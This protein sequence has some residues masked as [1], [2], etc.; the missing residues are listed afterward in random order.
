[1]AIDLLEREVRGLPE[2][3]ILRVIEFVR[4]IKYEAAQKKAKTPRR[5]PGHFSD[6]LLYIADDFDDTPE[7]FEEYM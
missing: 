2:E 7:G 3:D 6:Q 4:F 1:M 5:V